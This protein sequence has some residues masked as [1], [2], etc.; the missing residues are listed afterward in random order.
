MCEL[1]K[2]V[3]IKASRFSADMDAKQRDRMQRGFNDAAGEPHVLVLT[4]NLGSVSLNF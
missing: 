4:Y 2:K 1:Y 3:N